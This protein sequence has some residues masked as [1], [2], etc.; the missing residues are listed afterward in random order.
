[1]IVG[2]LGIVGAVG[3]L[4]TGILTKLQG[5]VYNAVASSGAPSTSATQSSTSGTGSAILTSAS[6][7]SGGSSGGLGFSEI[8][9]VAQ[10]AG[11]SQAGS[12]IAAAI[13]MAESGGNPNA[14]GDGGQSYGLWQ[15]Y[16]P[17]HPNVT[18]QQAENP[19]TAAQL[20]YSIS[21]G[22]QNWTPWSTYN[23]GSYLQFLGGV[24]T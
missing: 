10:Q 23:N 19:S 8:M 7:G 16:L 22:G 9:G 18:P 4:R 24:A 1:M 17:A 6:T 13:A 5:Y 12:M 20:A 15:I 2:S 14:V 21:S 3:L 11:F